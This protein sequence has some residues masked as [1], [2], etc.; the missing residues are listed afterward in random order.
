M[1]IKFWA[2]IVGLILLSSCSHPTVERGFYYWKSTAKSLTSAELNHLKQLNVQ[3][4]YVKFFEVDYS[5]EKGAF[6]ISKL[7]VRASNTLDSIEVIPTIFIKNIVFER[8]QNDDID[9][10]VD[11]VLFLIGKYYKE[12]ISKKEAFQE[13]QIDC[14][15]TKT[16]RDA[17]FSFLSKIKEQSKKTL[18][19]TMRLYPYKYMDIMGVPPVD[20]V[21]LMC[22][23]LIAPFSDENKNSIQNNEE[24]VKYLSEKNEYPLHTDIALPIFSWMHVYKNKRFAGL[25]SPF[26]IDSTNV[27]QLKPLWYE[28]QKDMELDDMFV[29]KGDVV[30]YEETTYPEII[31]TIDLLKTHIHNKKNTS[32]IL[33]H[34]DSININNFSNEEFSHIFDSFTL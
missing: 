12:R 28:V 22:Y 11:N 1:Y 8:L 3:K 30:K 24:L 21:T 25:I 6:P 26:K 29:R 16:T 23:N 18:S 34:L 20:K 33:Y 2:F 10:L 5:I 32:I 9:I 13:I 31:K 15:W 4:L 27:K 14:D 17:Y 19:C 7:Q